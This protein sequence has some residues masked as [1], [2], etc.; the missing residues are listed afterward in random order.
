MSDRRA[1]MDEWR[2]WYEGKRA[3]REQ[4]AAAR[5]KIIA[6]RYPHIV[7]SPDDYTIEQVSRC[8]DDPEVHESAEGSCRGVRCSSLHMVPLRR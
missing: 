6:A 8:N 3:W 7:E 1:R 2:E 5:E 4:M